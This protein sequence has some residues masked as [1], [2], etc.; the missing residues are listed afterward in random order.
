MRR[1]SFPWS[2][3]LQQRFFFDG[4]T[5]RREGD[6][7]LAVFALLKQKDG[8]LHEEAFHFHLVEE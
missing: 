4:Q 8:Q 7:S 3:V 5:F 1:S 6:D 2:S